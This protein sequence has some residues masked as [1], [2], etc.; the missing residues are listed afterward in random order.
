MLNKKNLNH[1]ERKLTDQVL[2]AVT[3]YVGNEEVRSLLAAGIN[4]LGENRVKNFL[5][6]YETFK[7]DDIT[8]HFIGHLQSKKVKKMINKIDF[9]HSLDRIS[10]ADEIE[11]RRNKPL[12][13]F[14]EVNIANDPNKY[15]L[16]PEN[17]LD[18]YNK[19]KDYDKI[20]V[21]GFMGMAKHTDNLAIIKENFQVL[22]DLKNLFDQ[23]IK[24]NKVSKLSMGMSND[25]EIAIEM[26]ATHL[27]I[28]SF[29][30]EEEYNGFI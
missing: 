20:N 30:Y 9:L 5:E 28:G 10:L 21:I 23:K 24:D 12:P 6:K 1:L 15:G 17:V 2:I 18:F 27:R 11:K 7:A 19:I 13:C 8:W 25:F 3:K 22:L 26:G 16:K 14:L 4:D 29:L